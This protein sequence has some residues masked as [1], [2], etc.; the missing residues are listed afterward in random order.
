MR[1]KALLLLAICLAIL[2]ALLL[3]FLF[4]NK[5][6][7]AQANAVP[8]EI[9]VTMYTLNQKGGID[10]TQEVTLCQITDD[11]YGCTAFPGE[12]TEYPYPYATNPV[13]VSIEADYLLDVVPRE[14]GPSGHHPL[15]LRAQAIAARTY[16]YCAIHAWEQQGEG[17]NYWG[18]CLREINNSNSFQVFIPY[19]FDT[20]TQADQQAVQNAVAEVAY[21]TYVE[22]PEEPDRAPSLPSFRP[23]LTC[24]RQ[25]GTM[26]TCAAWKT[27][28]ATTRPS[29]TSLLPP[30]L[31][32]G[33]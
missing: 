16:A 24:G 13:T 26:T 4:G 22:E 6:I 5:E 30:V 15:A 1:A 19:H 2:T 20:L 3:T 7:A 8:E 27:P 31:T 11:R 18:N 9:T 21:L 32:S 23:M 33:G 25:Q 12:G 28:S 17:G 10:W 14:M 29:Q